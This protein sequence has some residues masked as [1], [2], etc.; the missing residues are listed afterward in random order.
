MTDVL[1]GGGSR[2]ELGE[3]AGERDAQSRSKGAAADEDLTSCRRH[4]ETFLLAD[5]NCDP[6]V[7]ITRSALRE[8]R[9]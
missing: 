5:R 3:R 4:G 7:S 6:A 1:C 9:L 2:E 8:P